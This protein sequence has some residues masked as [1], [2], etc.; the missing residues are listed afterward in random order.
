M[1]GIIGVSGGDAGEQVLVALA[2]QQIAVVERFLAEIGQQ[3]IAIGRGD[4]GKAAGVHGFGI[5][6]YGRRRHHGGRNQLGGGE[7]CLIGHRY[8][9]A[10]ARL[11]CW[12]GRGLGLRGLCVQQIATYQRLLLLAKFHCAPLHLIDQT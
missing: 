1:F 10:L 2:R 3:R 11:L 6:W 7:I 8:C 9:R 12:C 5:F 4:D